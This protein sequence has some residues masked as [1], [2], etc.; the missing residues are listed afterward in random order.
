MIRLSIIINV[1]K[2]LVCRTS[3]LGY[4]H[5]V[6][7]NCS[8]SIKAPHSCKS[9][10]CPSCGKKA[11][12]IWIKNGFNTL[13]RTTW[14]HI[15]FTMPD[16]LWNFFWLNRYLINSIPLI[17]ASIIKDWA[18]R[19]GFLPGIYLAI[20][21]FGRDLK[22]NIHIHLSTTTGGLSFSHDTWINGAYFYHQSLK[23]TWRYKI[24]SLLREEFKKGKLI[25]P[26]HLQHC[27]SYTTFNSWTSQFYKKTWVVHLNTQSD[28]MKNN[29]DYLGKY[30]KRP[31]IGETR[32]KQ[33]DGKTV[34]YEYLDHYTDTKET[35]T[36][37]VLDFIARLICHI[38]DKH[39]RNIR[40]YGFLS[41]RLRGELLPIVY[42]L[43]NSKNMINTKVYIPWR[44][45][46]KDSFKYDPLK[47]PICNSF[48]ALKS[49]V[50]NNKYPLIS[51]HKEIAH[52]HFPLLL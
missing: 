33:Y 15:T 14:Q 42:K 11:T 46:I 16:E 22:K 51:Q 12:D 18:K 40:Y 26:A 10:F 3:F 48:M 35:M 47:C 21:T 32:I 52:G 5:F 1:L 43:L 45:M 37:P 13:P 38:P 30:L 28:N 50:F 49:V 27:T 25:L 9:R 23:N 4:H 44:N 7:L 20:H 29:I 19:K 34:S 36:L 2:L 41:N 24:I 31:P 39:F 17:A 8:K 6:C